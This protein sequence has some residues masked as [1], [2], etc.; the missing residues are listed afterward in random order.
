MEEKKTHNKKLMIAVLQLL[1]ESKHIDDKTFNI[2]ISKIEN[3]QSRGWRNPYI[4]PIEKVEHKYNLSI[5]L[6]YMWSTFESGSNQHCL[7]EIPN[8]G[9]FV[10]S[11]DF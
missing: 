7:V 4:P 8:D 11:G 1:L 2:A 10:S 9:W 6:N 5:Y 3:Q